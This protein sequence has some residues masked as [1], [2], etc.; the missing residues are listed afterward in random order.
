MEIFVEIFVMDRHGRMEEGEEG[1]KDEEWRT[2]TDRF[3]I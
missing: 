1:R 3:S 2:R